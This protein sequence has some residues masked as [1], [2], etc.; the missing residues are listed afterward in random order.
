MPAAELRLTVTV[1]GPPLPGSALCHD[2]GHLPFSHA[3]EDLLPDGENHETITKTLIESDEITDVLT[4]ETVPPIRVEDVVEIAVKTPGLPPWKQL[5]A[6][7]IQSDFFGVDRIDYLLRDSYHAGVAYGR[8]DHFRLLDTLRIL[9]PPPAPE[10]ES[11]ED[12][13]SRWR[14]RRPLLASNE[15]AL[16]RLRL[17]SSL[18]TSCLRRCTFTPSAGSTTFTSATFSALGLRTEGSRRVRPS[19]SRMDDNRVMTEIR[20]AAEE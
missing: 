11:G 2:I 15:E 17:F 20:V 8:F 7:I 6:E 14:R 13:G 1:F 12:G 10:Q 9:P 4:K 18:D 19:S 3:A 16:N 5:L